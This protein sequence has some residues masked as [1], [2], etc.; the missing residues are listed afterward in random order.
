[1]AHIKAEMFITATAIWIVQMWRFSLARHKYCSDRKWSLCACSWSITSLRLAITGSCRT[2]ESLHQK[3]GRLS[4]FAKVLSPFLNRQQTLRSLYELAG[5]QFLLGGQVR[6]ARK[7]W[8]YNG[9]P[10]NQQVDVLFFPSHT[11]PSTSTSAAW[12]DDL[13]FGTERVGSQIWPFNSKWINW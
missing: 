9:T 2:D 8:H 7:L 11:A 13:G 5:C 1:M 3:A 4:M 12:T 6:D 10:V